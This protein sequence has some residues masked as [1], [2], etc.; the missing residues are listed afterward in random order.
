MMDVTWLPGRQEF[1][2]QIERR[3]KNDETK[4]GKAGTA[5]DSDIPGNLGHAGLRSEF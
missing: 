1:N 3:K 4:K 2:L 5:P